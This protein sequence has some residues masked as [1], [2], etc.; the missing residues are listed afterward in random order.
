[1]KHKDLQELW[2]TTVTKRKT[3]RTRKTNNAPPM[4]EG[5]QTDYIRRADEEEETPEQVRVGGAS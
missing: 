3:R 4:C 2:R 1:M 5:E